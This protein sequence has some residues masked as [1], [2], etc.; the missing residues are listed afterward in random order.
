MS[1]Y[2]VGISEFLAISTQSPLKDF[3]QL[4]RQTTALASNIIAASSYDLTTNTL[5][6][7]RVGDVVSVGLLSASAY[8]PN[9]NFSAY[10]N[11]AN[12][13]VV[14]RQNVGASS[15]TN[16]ANVLSVVLKRQ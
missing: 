9:L 14:R 11:A 4:F 12:S 7:A 13:V 3:G 6:G 2:D 8:D 5:N 16:L 10:V 1:V 15:V